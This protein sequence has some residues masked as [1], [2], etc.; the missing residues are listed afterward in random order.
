[1]T[2]TE[3]KTQTVDIAT[4][5]ASN[6]RRTASRAR[7]LLTVE[8]VF[9]IVVV[10]GVWGFTLTTDSYFYPPLGEVLEKLWTVWLPRFGSDILPSLIRMLLGLAIAI[11]IGVLLGLL[12]GQSW[13]VRALLQPTLEFLRAVPASALIPVFML[14]F[15]IDDS[16]KIY[17]IAFVCL[18]PVLLN[19]IDGVSGLEPTLKE[20]AHVYQISKVRQQFKV[21]LPAAAP[22]IMAGVRISLA[23]SLIIMVLSEMVA[24]TNGIGYSVLQAQRTFAIPEMWAGI[25]IL[26]LV[27]YLLNLVFM[28]IER[29]VLAWHRGARAR[30]D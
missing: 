27:G 12:L 10:I 15:G 24:S 20:T 22:Q 30:Q 4:L 6:R 16:M 1:M 23:L 18:W 8:I 28:L 11:V 13:R 3:P 5:A 29:R 2:V 9:P 19:T 25:I 17:L 26:G 7:R 21:V 14:L